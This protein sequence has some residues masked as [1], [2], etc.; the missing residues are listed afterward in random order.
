MKI[1]HL[2]KKYPDAIGGDAVV[3]FH[4]GKQQLAAGHKVIIVTSNCK[5]IKAARHLYKFGLPDTPEALDAITIRR[6]L[7]LVMLFFQMFA[8]LNKERPDVIHTH[9]VDMAFIASF[10]ARWYHTPIVHTFHI[11]TFYD[12]SQSMMRRGTELWLAKQARPHRVTAPNKHDVKRLQNAGLA[13]ATL[14]PNG[15]D[16]AFWSKRE[17]GKK[18]RRITFVSVGR[19]EDQK[20]YTYLIKAVALL[21][22]I[23]N[24]RLVIVGDGARRVPLQTLINDLHLEDIVTLVGQKSPEE[25]RLL[26]ATSHAAVFPSLYE[27]TPLTLLEA[28]STGVPV[29]ATPVGIL[30]KPSSDFHAA[31]I[32]QPKDEV[33]LANAMRRLFLDSQYRRLIESE[34]IKEAKKYTWPA[35]GR[36]AELLYRNLK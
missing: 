20:G 29:I 4:L 11:V 24:L 9:S 16:T 2:T 32:V 22:D 35:I 21:A 6:L 15:V 7:S 25:I 28:W 1:L 33:A 34:G 26:L 18:S 5:E 14:L 8:I 17:P 27:T 19:L 23:P 12:D 30:Q 31:I 13:Q 36:T 10:A 3:V